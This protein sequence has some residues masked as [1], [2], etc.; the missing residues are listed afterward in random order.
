MFFAVK[1]L[2][3]LRNLAHILVIPFFAAAYVSGGAAAVGAD[4]V[5][6]WLQSS[7]I[8]W[9]RNSG[10]ILW[11]LCAVGITAV[12]FFLVD[13]GLQW[14]TEHV[15]VRLISHLLAPL[16]SFACLT[17]GLFVL[18]YSVPTLPRSPFNPFWHLGLLCYGFSLIDRSA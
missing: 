7:S 13:E 15:K 12:T 4:P 8:T 11:F 3:S 18:S 16:I 14:V 9:L 1:D 6:R 17:A 2:A 5:I 10:W